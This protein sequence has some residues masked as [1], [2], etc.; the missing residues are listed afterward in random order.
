M[1][2]VVD[3]DT[4]HAARVRVM[5]TSKRHGLDMSI[6]DMSSPLRDDVHGRTSLAACSQI[7]ELRWRLVS[8][9]C[10]SLD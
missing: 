8:L 10:W 9:Q 5:V 2:V 7:G 3:A 4:C 1:D 6:E